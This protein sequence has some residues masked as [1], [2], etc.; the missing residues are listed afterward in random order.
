MTGPWTAGG[1]AAPDAGTRLFC[2]A[3][4]GGGP[5][6]FRSWQRKLGPDLDVA[7]ILLPGRESRSRERPLR[8]VADVVG[9]LCDGLLPMLDRP[10]ALFGH[11]L[12][13]VLAYE[14]ARE[15]GARGW[16]EP[17]QLFVS[18]RRAPHLPAR[19]DPLHRLPEEQFLTAVGRM[20]GTPPEVLS[21]PGLLRAFAPVLRA[22][23]E[24]N[25][26]YVPLSGGLLG[27]PV[28]AVVGRADPQVGADEMAGWRDTT[29]GPFEL[30]VLDGDHFYLRQDPRELLALVRDRLGVPARS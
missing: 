1:P 7:P 16:G 4:A 17:R 2:F 28:S 6:G 10:F 26:T 22:D 25:E 23:F 12:G 27:C 19:L 30:R 21:H 8:R 14:T 15:L 9:R 29:R 5:A 24:L 13:A 18:A 20:G 11:S 3:H